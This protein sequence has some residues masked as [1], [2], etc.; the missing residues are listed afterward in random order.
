MGRYT[1]PKERL[2]RKEGVNLY[3]K[4]SR[5]FSE[6]AG[7]KRRPFGPGQHGNARKTRLSNY[8]IQLREKQKVKRLYGMREKQFHNLYVESIRRSKV[9]NS[10]KG[11]EL[12]RML[13][14]RLDNI[15]YISGLAASKGAAR[16][17]VTHKHV[18]VNGK[19]LN[20]PSYEVKVGDVVTLKMDKLAP[21]EVLVKT[22]SWVEKTKLTAK[23]TSLPVREMIDE[24]IREN[25]IVEFY[26]R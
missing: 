18:L 3:L 19:S 8:G 20:V 24:G 12:L 14:T 11:L 4:G 26:S 22:P 10:D 5:S 25:L 17:F 6:K 2:S 21:V 16:Q 23:V 15:L 13:E 7:I 9:N 1:G